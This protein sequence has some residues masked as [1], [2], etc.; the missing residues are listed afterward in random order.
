[1]YNIYTSFVK[2]E[3][4]NEKKKDIEPEL[5]NDT[6]KEQKKVMLWSLPRMHLWFYVIKERIEI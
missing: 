1:M 4:K 3:Q 5:Q 6:E 2:Q